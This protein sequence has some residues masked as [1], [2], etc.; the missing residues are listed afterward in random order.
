[1]TAIRIEG[2]GHVYPDGT[3]ALEGI[4][5]EIPAGQPIAIVGSNGSGKSTLVRHLD[6]LLRPT[7][8][9]V[10]LD[11]ADIA[12]RRVASLA[13]TVGI[14]FQDPDRQ[15]FAGR[16]STEVAFGARNVGLLG[17]ALE[18]A[19]GRALAA[20][21]LDAEADSNPYDL[22]PARRKLLTVAAVLAMG[23]PVVVLDEPTMGQ[24]GH[25]IDRIRRIVEGLAGEG[26]TVVGISHNLQFV[27]DAFERV[28]VLAAGRVVLDGPP[29]RVL[30]A[31]E[32]DR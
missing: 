27:A 16:V 7:E 31:R 8:G 28:V 5:L 4:D 21:G 6:G 11:G 26:R 3:R 24:D 14:V 18:S 23:T 1:M 32:P 19:V 30:A 20:V 22:G 13:A 17:A 2:L 29:S 9:R 12:G 25:G 10:L 15:I